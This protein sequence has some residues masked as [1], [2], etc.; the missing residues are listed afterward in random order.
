[1]AK[2]RR[3]N[4]QT[5]SSP[6]PRKQKKVPRRKTVKTIMVRSG[7]AKAGKGKK[8]N[9]QHFIKDAII[10][11]GTVIAGAYALGKLPTTISP[12]IL[13]LGSLAAGGLL[14][15]KTKSEITKSIGTGLIAL[16]GVTLVKSFFPTVQTVAGEDQISGEMQ[17]MGEMQLTGADQQLLDVT[18]GEDYSGEEYAGEVVDYTSGVDWQ[19]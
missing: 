19:T 18:T 7:R 4:K 9:M 1:M 10:I 3:K 16:G 8:Y 14:G 2:K 5:I 11:T 17:M 15:I 6:L 13:A 12:K